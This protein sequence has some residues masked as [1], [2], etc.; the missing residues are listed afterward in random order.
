MTSKY[1]DISSFHVNNETEYIDIFNNVS[2]SGTLIYNSSNIPEKLI[3]SFPLNWEI[4]DV[5][6]E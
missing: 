4:I 1:I 3:E 2:K 6:Y 5:N